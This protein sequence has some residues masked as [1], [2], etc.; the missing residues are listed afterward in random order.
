M[1]TVRSYEEKD[2]PQMTEIWNQVVEEGNAFPG[3]ECY[4]EV[5]MSRFLK[6][7]SSAVCA[8]EDG[9][10][11]GMYI[12][13][14][15]NI[16]RCGHIANA[17]YAVNRAARGKGV[18]ELLVRHCLRE[19]YR[20]GFRG[21]Q[22]NAVVECNYAANHLYQKLGFTRIGMVPNGYRM[23]DG[24]YQNIILYYHDAVQE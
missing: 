15:N 10:I 7:Q 20:C 19:T 6:E 21:L 4:D 12:L 17:S 14:P 9:Q 8:V 3:E 2:I 23:K 18:G 24:S 5:G 16:G 22:F 13:H 11:V 1:I